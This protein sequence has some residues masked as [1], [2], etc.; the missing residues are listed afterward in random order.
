VYTVT[1]VLEIVAVVLTALLVFFVC[2]HYHRGSHHG[3][4]RGRL[5]AAVGACLLAA[6]AFITFAAGVAYEQNGETISGIDTHSF[7]DGDNAQP[8]AG[9]YLTVAAF[10]CLAVGVYW[11]H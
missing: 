2:C 11:V 10:F 6:A 4:S 9:W 7:W 8:N 3:G 5:S 1:M